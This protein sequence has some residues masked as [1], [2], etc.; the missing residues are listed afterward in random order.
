[1]WELGL[2]TIAVVILFVVVAAVLIYNLVRSP[3]DHVPGR[4][5][6]Y[7]RLFIK[8]S[9]VILPVV[10]R[11]I[12]ALGAHG[13][14]RW[15]V[16]IREV[17]ESAGLYDMDE[18][19]LM[20]LQVIVSVALYV[21][22]LLVLHN[23]LTPAPLLLIGWYYPILIMHRLASERKEAMYGEL[24]YV[25]DLLSLGIEAGLD[26]KTSVE[27]LV[28]FSEPSPLMSELRAL[29][30]DLQL[31]TPMEDAL[32]KMR[33]R[34]DV[35]AFFTFVEAL[36]QATQIGI[37]VSTTLRAQAEQMRVTF[38][39]DLEKQANAIPIAILL[40]SVLFIFPPL[41]FVVLGPIFMQIVNHP[42][43]QAAAKP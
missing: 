41:L 27:R 13:K 38:F 43:F 3:E 33:K 6:P 9:Y 5:P 23:P 30:N 39:Q 2:G 18:E 26:F 21:V 10:R 34:I 29:L 11:L 35:L 36:I 15:G 24:P 22:F 19:D 16:Y 17:R 32:M 42:A 37:D 25:L 31:G 7:A 1:M 40:P 4:L 20:S 12:G 28:N 14:S 8:V